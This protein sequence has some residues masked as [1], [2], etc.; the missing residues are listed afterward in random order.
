[1]FLNT[2]VVMLKCVSSLKIIEALVAKKTDVTGNPEIRANQNTSGFELEE[3][4]DH[5]VAFYKNYQFI[6]L[7]ISFTAF[8][9]RNVTTYF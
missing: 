9:E 1:M 3:T 4:R 5:V 7:S 6:K 2:H 8:P